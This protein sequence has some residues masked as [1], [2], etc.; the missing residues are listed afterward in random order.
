MDS[1]LIHRPSAQNRWHNTRKV[2]EIYLVL[3]ILQYSD[4]SWLWDQWHWIT[5]C[6]VFPCLCWTSKSE[7]GCVRC[8]NLKARWSWTPSWIWSQALKSTSSLRSPQRVGFLSTLTPLQVTTKV[9]SDLHMNPLTRRAIQTFRESTTSL[10]APRQP[11]CLRDKSP[12]CSLRSHGG[13]YYDVPPLSN[14]GQS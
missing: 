3:T 11:S 6:R 10:R 7:A 14:D 8:V 9:N 12:R 2:L 1:N 5:Y 4:F 13:T